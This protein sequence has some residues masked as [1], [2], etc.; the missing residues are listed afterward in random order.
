MRLLKQ[1]IATVEKINSTEI[2][3]WG[4]GNWGP[5]RSCSPEDTRRGKEEAHIRVR[6]RARGMSIHFTDSKQV[7]RKN[8]NNL[9]SISIDKTPFF[10]RYIEP[11]SPRN[12]YLEKSSFILKNLQ[13]KILYCGGIFTKLHTKNEINRFYTNFSSNSILWV[14]SLHP[15]ETIILEDKKS[16][17]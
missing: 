9:L 8:V 13:L 4:W 6:P 15:Y 1:E 17:Y 5:F 12:R 16:L 2:W 14:L 10:D 7:I 3:F 11:C